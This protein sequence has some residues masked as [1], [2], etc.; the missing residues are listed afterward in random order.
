MENLSKEIITFTYKKTTR[1]PK[2]LENNVFII[3]SPEKIKLEPWENKIINM[4]IKI[5]FPKRIE[6]SCRLLYSISN[7]KII[8]MNSNIISQEINSNIEMGTYYNENDL[9][10]WNLNFELFNWNFNKTIQTRKKQE[11]GYF[12]IINDRGK[13]IH[14]KYEKEEN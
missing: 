1:K 3:Y 9:P 7:E 12:Y 10:P 2:R 14:F 4:Q 13:E 5:F 11:L 8:L 6:G